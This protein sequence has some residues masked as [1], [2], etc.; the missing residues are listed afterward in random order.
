MNNDEDCN[1]PQ[2]QFVYDNWQQRQ[3]IIEMDEQNGGHVCCRG[4]Y[5]CQ[6][7]ASITITATTSDILVCSGRYSC[8]DAVINTFHPV[9]CEG[10]SACSLTTINKADNIYCLG[11]M[12]CW[13]S[14]ITNCSVVYC[15]GSWACYYSVIRN[16]IH[17][18]LLGYNSG[19]YTDIYCDDISDKCEITCGGYLSCSS[20]TLYCNNNCNV[21]CNS[22]TGCPNGNYTILTL[23]PTN[24]LT[25]NPTYPP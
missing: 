23:S 3:Q 6:Y 19:R 21:Y 5:S 14:N 20:T 25:Y 8:K 1:Q 11:Y 15:S 7:D 2:L 17:V 24:N 12:A 10:S 16:P 9:F 18:H 13:S 22:D 4:S